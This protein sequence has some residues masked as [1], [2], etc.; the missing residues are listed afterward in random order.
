ME[1]L[2]ADQKVQRVCSNERRLTAQYGKVGAKKVSLRLQQLS[3]AAT[4]EDMRNLP[5]R[6]HELTDNREGQ[7]AVDLD[8]PRRLVFKPTLNPAP[9]KPDGGLDWDAVESITVI[10]IVDYH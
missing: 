5:G 1:V 4:L 10:E 9:S 2:F 8:H 7:L 6:C 3:A